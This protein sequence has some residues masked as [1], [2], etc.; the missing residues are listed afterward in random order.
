V[1]DDARG[2]QT[3]EALQAFV[4]AADAPG[5]DVA[6]RADLRLDLAYAL[7]QLS[8]RDRDCSPSATVAISRRARS[9]IC[10]P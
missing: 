5:A 10:S 7:A 4:E 1:I 2:R 8:E 3:L 6:E 9:R